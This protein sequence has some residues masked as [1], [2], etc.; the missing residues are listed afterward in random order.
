[1]RRAFRLAYDGRPFRGYQR[2]P[3]V[4]TVEGALL[5][6]LADLGVVDAPGDPGAA[7]EYAAPHPPTPPGY[8]AAGRTDAGVWALAQTVAFDAPE[9][10]RP[11]ALN[12]E[13]PPSV[14]AWA[15]AD[16]PGLHA[17]HDAT[18]REYEYHCHA[19]GAD[20]DRARTALSALAGRHDFRNLT[21]DREDTV[22]T[23]LATDCRVDGDFLVL[24]V[25][26]EGFLREMVRRVA[27][28]VAAVATGERS[29]SAVEALL[30]GPA[31][32]G[33]AGVAP[34][35]AEGLVLVDVGY[36][37]LAFEADP[38]AVDSL[39]TVFGDAAVAA[40]RRAR[41]AHRVRSGVD[42]PG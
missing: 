25:R 42:R 2:Q 15:S 3:S 33:P 28:L 30:D 22:R 20:P 35:P 19:P 34:A 31:V 8:A 14:R 26:A 39:R 27:T 11:R 7:G 5:A 17:T 1:V 18:Y 38:E 12:A 10:C 24:T 13:L 23:V 40:S 37:E 4:P 36:P 16:A 32:D 21:A 6:A 9:W 29:P 41:V